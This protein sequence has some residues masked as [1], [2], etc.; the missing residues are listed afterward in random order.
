MGWEGMKSDVMD[1][2][3]SDEM[4]WNEMGWDCLRWDGKGGTSS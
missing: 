1:S 3:R 2:I 4:G